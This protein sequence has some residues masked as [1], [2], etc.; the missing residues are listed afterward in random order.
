MCIIT[1]GRVS[2]F[3]TGNAAISKAESRECELLKISK[4]STSKRPIRSC[5]IVINSFVAKRRMLNFD[6]T[7]L[8]SGVC[9]LFILGM[10]TWRTHAVTINILS[11]QTR[12]GQIAW[13]S[14]RNYCVQL[15]ARSPRKSY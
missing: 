2:L 5:A 11:E 4:C 7:S 14:H 8:V 12:V 3:V 10:Q 15:V 13:L 9:P 6:S 1:Q